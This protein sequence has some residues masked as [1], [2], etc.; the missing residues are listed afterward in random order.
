MQLI[1]RRLGVAEMERP[2]TQRDQFNNEDVDLVDAL[3]RESIQNSL[4]AK[5][6]AH[7]VRVAFAIKKIEPHE[8]SDFSYFLDLE[9]LESHMQDCKMETDCLASKEIRLLLIEDFGTKGLAGETASWDEQP[10]CD[11]W[12]RMGV[13]NK[14][15]RSLGRWGLGKLVFSSS[16]QARI[17]YGYTIRPTD[18]SNAYLMGQAVVTTHPDK[19]GNR[20]DSHGFYA[21]NGPD[22]IQ[23]PESDQ[24]ILGKF[25]SATK[26]K[27]KNEPGLS[28]VVPYVS[29]KFTDERIVR[30]V[31]KNYFFPI[32]TGQLKVSVGQL[33]VNAESFVEQAKRYG[34]ERFSDG[35]LAAFIGM[36]QQAWSDAREPIKLPSNW[37]KLTS[38]ECLG[39][40]LDQLRIDLAEGKLIYV[41]T[42]I[43]LKK[44]T[45]E[46]IS[47]FV[48]LFIKKSEGTQCDT[49]FV[50]D[51]IV[52]PAEAKYFRGKNVFAALVARDSAI[53]S[54][55]GDAENPAHTSWSATAEKLS[56]NWKNA[57]ERLKEVRSALNKV[58]AALFSSIEVIDEN[59]LIDVFSIAR[60]A[61]AAGPKEN[62]KK[63]TPPLPELPPVDKRKFRVEKLEGG[64]SLKP[65]QGLEDSDLPLDIRVRAAYD[66]LRGNPFKKFDVL[67]FSF[68]KQP[69]VI[70]A[71]GAETQ[72][73][74]ANSLLV[75]VTSANFLVTVSGFDGRRDLIIDPVRK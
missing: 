19:H 67:D 66:V 14:Q 57:A 52:L 64:F 9:T 17:F 70:N 20:Y 36:M 15:G 72:V 39:E 62:G 58:Y 2:P 12:R 60:D 59:A 75:T 11:F 41:S 1:F 53:C 21:V 34:D 63:V 8:Y 31:V 24:E 25:R 28:I 51:T 27:R 73:L 55:L 68:A 71:D 37:T 33:E 7:E 54:F 74:S 46:E 16:S 23:C 69:I 40:D 48:D 45:G 3:V 10:F 5:A 26:M 22:D 50:R 38:E 6:G 43:L 35:H 18:S 49:L 61:G 4:D 29:D 44:K 65:G 47:T 42:P 56:K 30:G 13:S 32:L